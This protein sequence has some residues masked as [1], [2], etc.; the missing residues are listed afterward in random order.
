MKTI[1]QFRWWVAALI[2]IFTVALTVVSPSLSNLAADKETL[3]IPEEETSS[4][5]QE[6]LDENGEGGNTISAVIQTENEAGEQEQENIQSLI[7]AIEEENIE[8]ISEVTDPFGSEE[9]E[10]QLVASEENVVVI[11]I[12]IEGNND[13][14][15]NAAEE[16]RSLD[17]ASNMEMYVTGE[18]LLNQQV[19][20][21]SQEGLE[22]TEVITVVLILALLFV[23]FR[24]VIT[25][26][27]PLIAVGLTYLISQSIIAYLVDWFNFPVSNYTQ[28]FLVA[29]LFGIGT[30]YCILLLSRY[31]EELAAGLDYKKAIIRT[32]K[33]AGKT[34]V[35]SALAVL[36]GFTAIGFANFSVFQSGVGVA[37]GIV[38]LTGVLWTI[39]PFFM[40]TLKKALFWPSKLHN[41][42]AD[43][44]IWKWLS[45]ISVFRPLLAILIVAV[46]TV[47]LLLTFDNSRSYDTIDEIDQD[48]EEVTGLNLIEE[49]LGSGQALP[50]QIVIESDDSVMESDTLAYVEDLSRSISNLEEVEEVR[51][52][53]RPAGDIIDDFYV[54]NQLEEVSNGISDARD[55]IEETESG[56]QEVENGLSSI[57]EQLGSNDTENS[58]LQDAADGLGEVNTALEQVSTQLANASSPQEAAAASEQLAGISQQL[59][60]IQS[61]LE[62]GQQELD[63]QT[64]ELEQL[65]ETL[66]TLENG[67]SDSRDGLTE[68]SDGLESAET[69]TGEVSEANYV[70]GTG[71]YLPE[72]TIENEDFQDG[73]SNYVFDNENGMTIEVGLNADPYSK[74]AIQSAEEVKEVMEMNT[75]GTPLEDTTIEY[76]GVP[77]VNSDLQ[78]VSSSDF[79]R[80]V[81]IVLVGIFA[82]LIILLRNI[83]QPLYIIGGLVLAYFTAMAVTE[84]IFVNGLGY[85]GIAWP[86][87]FFGFVMLVALGV[88]YSIFLLSRYNEEAKAG[89]RT[90]MQTAM[91]KMGTVIITAAIIL[92]GTFAAMLPS[93]VLTLLEVATVV[94]TG[95]LLFGLIVLPLLIPALI[96]FNSEEKNPKKKQKQQER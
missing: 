22:R 34:M 9:T 47:P 85:P 73:A 4:Q 82:I 65:A 58:S 63:Q 60:E 14:A 93:G 61:G 20:E 39:L 77:S 35:Y 42:H 38:V 80:T 67:V 31:R 15:V 92:S 66:G 26:F 87:P 3:Q 28:I 48:T 16:I 24:A 41:G 74:E 36:V 6:I 52:A 95:L 79:D 62:E 68:I 51:S 49:G 90:G 96:S 89:I 11:P 33:T 72:D 25:P 40:L 45:H 59:T 7:T 46:V 53:T 69:F 54:N 12:S 71:V 81:L 86:V 56:L 1:L 10:E 30:D 70:E 43:S 18:S 32:Y 27:V 5:A 64:A 91:I 84:L 76:G 83:I 78:S 75:Q 50:M 44:K 19:N 8:G 94:I 13:A 29:V 57:Q 88:D 55:G 21:A 37:V 17:E 23:V 2:V